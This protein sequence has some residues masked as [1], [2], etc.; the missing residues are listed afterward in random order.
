MIRKALKEFYFY[1][2]FIL[3]GLMG[4]IC[5]LLLTFF[6]TDFL[7]WW[8]FFSYVSSTLIGWTFIFILNSRFTFQRGTLGTWPTEYFKFLSVYLFMGLI[9]FSLVFFLTSIMGIYYILSI[10]VVVIPISVF[11]FLLN[12]YYVFT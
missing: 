9:N 5:I 4:T 8:Y 1:P 12:K 11:N 3:I 10:V 2:Q 6:L 7:G